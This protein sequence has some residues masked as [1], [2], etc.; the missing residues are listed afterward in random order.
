MKTKSLHLIHIILIVFILTNCRSF[1]NKSFNLPK[2]GDLI[3]KKT[4]KE[5]VISRYGKPHNEVKKLM[6]GKM[7]LFLRYRDASASFWTGEFTGEKVM[8]FGFYNDKLCGYFLH[9]AFDEAQKDIDE[10]NIELIQKGISNQKNIY[11][12]FSKPNGVYIYPAIEEEL[13][14]NDKELHYF[15]K[16]YND[17]LKYTFKKLRFVLDSNSVVKKVDYFTSTTK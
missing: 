14:N 12:L 2:T 13:E 4:T 5:E 1:E 15:Y 9:N 10:S 6:N 17:R 7:I 8:T 3:L 16:K 11:R